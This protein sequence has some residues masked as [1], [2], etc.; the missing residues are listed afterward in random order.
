MT[1]PYIFLYLIKSPTFLQ[2]FLDFFVQFCYCET[3]INQGGYL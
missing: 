2:C 3:N 1:P